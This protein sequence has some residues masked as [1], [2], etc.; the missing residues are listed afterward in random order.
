[1]TVHAIDLCVGWVKVAECVDGVFDGV[2]RNLAAGEWRLSGAVDALDFAGGFELADVDTVRVVR[3]TSVVFPGYVSP[4]ASGIGGLDVVKS[5][6]G[7]MFTLT[8]SD[9]WSVLASRL[10]WP[11]PGTVPPWS[12]SWDAEAGLASTVASA[13]IL[14][15]AGNLALAARQIP[16]LTV[17]DGSAG[18]TG[19]WSGR[20]QPL[21]QHVARICKEGAIV[22]RFAVDFTGAVQ[23]TLRKPA[24]RST[25]IVLSDQGDLTKIQTI[26]A[27]ESTTFVVTGGQG[28]LNAR[29]FTTA[30]IA[31]GAARR[32]VFSDQSS[33]STST[34]LQQSADATLAFAAATLTVRAEV[35]D[36]AA[37]RFQYLIDYDIGDTVAV[38]IEDVRY[39]VV[40]ESVTV[41]VA[42]DRAVIRPVLGDASPN[43]VT[44]LIRDVANLASRFDTQIA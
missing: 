8:G 3:D 33:L 32:E 18:L 23:V 43:L 40:V 41:H 44:G 12:D 24:D 11:T 27:P 28:A 9:A 26:E 30:G 16:G 22:C 15:N 37:L 6:A 29:T 4:V 39:P 34:E 7:D 5:A 17:V 2:V 20:L 36:S 14:N 31:T 38:E 19:S 21:D 25:T 35:A 13:Y 42:P 10:V 1:M